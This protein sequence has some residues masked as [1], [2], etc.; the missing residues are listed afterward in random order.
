MKRAT[1]T[2]LSLAV[3]AFVL[4]VAVGDTLDPFMP[5]DRQDCIY[6]LL[7]RGAETRGAFGLC[8]EMFPDKP[9]DEPLD[10]S[11]HAI[12]PRTGKHQARLPD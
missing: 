10:L 6:G 5:A 2:W 12:D 9:V 8:K 7:R 4:G 11:S 1:A 3:G